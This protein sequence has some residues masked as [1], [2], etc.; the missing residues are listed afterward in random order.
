MTVR[1]TTSELQKNFGQWHDRAQREPVQIVKHGRE[2]AYLISS[3]TYEEL[4][5]G[6]RRV[7]R[8][9][10]LTEAEMAMIMDAEI[11]P[12]NRYEIDDLEAEDSSSS[13]S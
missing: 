7:V 10:E 11:A 8:V 1:V 4:L 12:E 6:Y 3:A 13:A 2:T 9:D 5:V